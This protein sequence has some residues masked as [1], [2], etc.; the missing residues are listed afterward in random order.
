[1]KQDFVICKEDGTW[2]VEHWEICEGVSPL[3]FATV[4]YGVERYRKAVYIFPLD[5]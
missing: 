4:L 2:I 5:A 3:D 1:M